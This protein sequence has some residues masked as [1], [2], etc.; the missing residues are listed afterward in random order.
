M[1]YINNKNVLMDLLDFNGLLLQLGTE[2]LRNDFDLVF[3]A[4]SNNGM[5]L[6]Y[7][8]LNLRNNYEIII[9]EI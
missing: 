8:T 7:S 1:F 4:V 9:S 5:A 6:K 3:K 2:N